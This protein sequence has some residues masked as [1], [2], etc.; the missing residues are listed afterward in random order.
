MKGQEH[1]G[2]L[3]GCIPPPF[4][5]VC[6]GPPTG[7]LIPWC[8]LRLENTCT[9]TY[10]MC[11]DIYNPTAGAHSMAVEQKNLSS[12]VIECK[13]SLLFLPGSATHYHYTS[14][15]IHTHFLRALIEDALLQHQHTG[16]PF[17]RI[18]GA[19]VEQSSP[20]SHSFS[21]GT[22]IRLFTLKLKIHTHIADIIS[23][24]QKRVSLYIGIG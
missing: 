1:I 10:E 19:A 8:R 9:N 11:N 12:D 15:G 16:S 6:V 20:S 24:G 21:K 3:I 7:N 22:R 17:Y 23:I 4:G 2:H 13:W 18:I 14:L 5:D